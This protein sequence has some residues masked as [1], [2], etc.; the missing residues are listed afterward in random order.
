MHVILCISI[1]IIYIQVPLGVIPKNENQLKQM[2]QILDHMY[3]Y[4]PE[5]AYTAQLTV[6]NS[7]ESVTIHQA[8]T[9]KILVGGDQLSQVQAKAAI[10]IKANAETPLS[11]LEGLLP[12]IEDWHTKLTLFEVN[13]I[14]LTI[15]AII[16]N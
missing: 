6:P 8:K 7:D 2:V 9:H 10:T 11:R 13:N 3:R 5:I 16:D 4:V 1:F 15:L 14:N 12:T